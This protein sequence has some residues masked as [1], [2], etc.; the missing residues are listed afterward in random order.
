[1]VEKKVVKLG[2][3]FHVT[4]ERR[5]LHTDFSGDRPHVQGVITIAFQNLRGRSDN[6]IAG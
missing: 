4:V 2:A 6:F 3:V 5:C 1:M